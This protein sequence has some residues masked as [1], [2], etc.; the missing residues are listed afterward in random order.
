MRRPVKKTN[1]LTADS[2][3]GSLEVSKLINYVMERGKKTVAQRVVYSAF[4]L[5][6]EKTGQEPLE[7]FKETIKNISPQMEIRS[8][9]I[10][11]ANYQ[12]PHE[13]RPA[14]QLSLALRWLIKSARAKSGTK[15]EIRLADEIVSAYNNEGEAVK[16]KEMVHKMAEANRAFAHFAWTG[17]KKKK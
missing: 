7:V 3:H 15:M 5:V 14:R 12:V 4:G 6:K 9:R 16:K 8:R 13:V 1:R 2:Q 11:G 10:G 17:K